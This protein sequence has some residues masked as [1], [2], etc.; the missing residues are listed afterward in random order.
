MKFVREIPVKYE[1]DVFV[2]GGGPAGIAAALTADRAGAAVYLAEKGQCFGG[3]GTLA[4][5]PAFMRF[6]DGEHFLA[7]G[8]GRRIFEELYGKDADDTVIEYAIETEKLKTIYDRMLMESNVTFSFE[9]HIIGIEQAD[10]A[11]TTAVIMGKENLFAVNAKFF[12]DATGDGT[13]AV[14]AGATYDKGDEAGRMMPGSLCTLWGGID[15]NRAVV[16]LGKDPD[17]RRLPQA[18]ADG[19]FT[20][21]DPGLPGM[22]RRPDG[23]G[24]G[25]IGHVFGVDG[26]DEKSITDGI[27]DARTRMKEY[28]A[29]YRNYLEGYENAEMLASGSVLGIRETRRLRCEYTMCMQDYFEQAD[30]EDEI[31]RYNYPVDVHAATVDEKPKYPGIYEKGYPRGKSYGISY[32][33]LLPK[34]TRNILAAGRCVGADREMAGSMRVMPGCYITGMAA[35]AAAALA[36]KEKTGLRELDVKKLQRELKAQGAYLPNAD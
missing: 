12:I 2:A 13:L 30:F 6:S 25:N 27:I 3:M 23:F 36:A 14:W 32:R 19:V 34:G 21:K 15:W 28:R 20:V 4:M 17:N 11:V 18:F 24:G 8:I 35:G 29:Y 22:W 16:E 5:V 31:G 10:G 7:G 9:N 1:V 33:A 26:T